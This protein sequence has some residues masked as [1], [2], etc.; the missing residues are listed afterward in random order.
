MWAR[1]KIEMPDAR[2]QQLRQFLEYM[3]ASELTLQEF[4]NM[5]LANL[6]ASFGP[7]CIVSIET[8][9]AGS[10]PAQNT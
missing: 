4:L 5:N 1:V 3:N 9:G 7:E 6:Q 8:L 10:A 2:G